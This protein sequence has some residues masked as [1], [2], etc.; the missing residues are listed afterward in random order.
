MNSTKET[1]IDRFHYSDRGVDCV[2]RLYK[3]SEGY[4]ITVSRVKTYSRTPV[5]LVKYGQRESAAMKN[6]ECLKSRV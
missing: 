2:A 6:W 5:T 4:K 1:T 3:D